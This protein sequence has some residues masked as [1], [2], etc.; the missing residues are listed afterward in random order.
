[1]QLER[2]AKAEAREKVYE[3]IDRHPVNESDLLK[4]SKVDPAFRREMWDLMSTRAR[5]R[6]AGKGG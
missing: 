1:M 5:Q 3:E 2:E 4:E 6:R